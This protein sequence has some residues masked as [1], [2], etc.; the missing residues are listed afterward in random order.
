MSQ[1][2]FIMYPVFQETADQGYKIVK[3]LQG[4]KRQVVIK[5]RS[6][7][8]GSHLSSLQQDKQILEEEIKEM[9]QN[10]QM[11]LKSP[12]RIADK[13]DEDYVPKKFLKSN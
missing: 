5:H 8:Q 3:Q 2:N 10:K 11:P 6:A 1:K 7:N 13:E 4:Y 12:K 9:K